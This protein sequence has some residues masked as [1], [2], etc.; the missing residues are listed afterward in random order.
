VQKANAASDSVADSARRPGK[1]PFRRGGSYKAE[2]AEAQ[3]TRSAYLL[4]GRRVTIGDLIGSAPLHLVICC[5]LSD[6]AWAD[7][8]VAGR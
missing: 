4:D 7:R 8:P 1:G 2:Q 5:G 6:L 3:E